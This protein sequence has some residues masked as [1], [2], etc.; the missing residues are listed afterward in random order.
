[1]R[2]VN[3]LL[4]DVAFQKARWTGGEITPTIVVLHDTAGRLEKGNSAR[5][6]ADNPA[7]VSVH[8]VVEQ[9]GTIT[10]QVLTNRRANHAGKSNFNGRANCNDFSIGIEIVNP[11]RMTRVNATQAVA[12]W[13][14]QMATTLFDIREMT[15]PEHGHGLWMNY[16]E[17][18]L[19]AVI[20][21]LEALFAAIPTLKDITTHWYV[22]PGRKVD[23]NPLF[24]LDHVRARVLGRDDPA[25]IEA[26]LASKPVTPNRDDPGFVVIETPGDNL[27]L[28]RWP[29][30]NPNV[31]T[32]IP[33]ASVVPVLRKGM[34]DG[35]LWLCTT[36]GGHEGWVLA[37]HTAPILIQTQGFHDA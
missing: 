16:P 27:N 20:S 6:L 26:E 11:G 25:D 22:S 10:Q 9:D 14:Q 34:F 23:T 1:M 18:Q 24:P 3:H 12:W 4:S 13:G 36:Y 15:T 2:I 21:L 8:F 5:Y 32:A 17:L 35:R 30:F 28:R 7:Q 33:D 31:L 29:S 37:V 19:A